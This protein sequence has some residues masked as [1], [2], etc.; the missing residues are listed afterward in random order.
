LRG[1]NL[2]PRP[3]LRL[4]PGQV[5]HLTLYWQ[6]DRPMSQSF[7]VFT[8][9]VGADGKIYGQEDLVPANGKS[10]TDGWVSGEVTVDQY[11]IPLS[12]TA[13][14]G[15]YQLEIGLYQ[16]QDGKRLPLTGAGGDSL[17]LAS[18]KVSG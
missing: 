11:S 16:P 3:G 1:F 7:T 13:P 2:S 4:A 14:P 10:P 18:V 15:Q 6:D 5:V 17:D 12:T 8:H 9:L